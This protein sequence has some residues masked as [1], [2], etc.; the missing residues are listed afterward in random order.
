MR[1]EKPVY[2]AAHILADLLNL[3]AFVPVARVQPA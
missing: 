1:R 2:F 3:L